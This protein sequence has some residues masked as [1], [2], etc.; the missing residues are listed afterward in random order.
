[1]GPPCDGKVKKTAIATRTSKAPVVSRAYR[2]EMMREIA[3]AL[4]SA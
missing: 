3:S 1:M 2:P 4:E